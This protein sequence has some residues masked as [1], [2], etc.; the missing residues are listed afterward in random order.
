MVPA[1]SLDPSS[2]RPRRPATRASPYVAAPTTSTRPARCGVS[3]SGAAAHAQDDRA[4][5][6]RDVQVED[7]APRG[8]DDGRDRPAQPCRG[9]DLLR[10]DRREDGGPDDGPGGHSEEGQGADDA[11]CPRARGTTEQVRRRGGPDRHEHASADRLDEPSRDE[12]VE[13]LGGTRQ[14]GP[15]REDDEGA[16]QQPSRAPQVGQPSGHRH[17][18]DVDEEVAVDDPARLAQ[19]DPCGA[20]GRVGQVG[21]DRWQGDRRDDE[22]EAGQEDT[23]PD[24]GEQHEP[25]AAVML[26]S[27]VVPTLGAPEVRLDGTVSSPPPRGWPRNGEATRC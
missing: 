8:L 20:T 3:Q 11:E 12:L 10:V 6:D 1:I 4:D 9:D 15:D 22:L 18:Q 14:G 21:Q 19:L 5:P 27:V 25:R 7:P 16:H 24:D 2:V 23:R 13:G 26:G 17:R